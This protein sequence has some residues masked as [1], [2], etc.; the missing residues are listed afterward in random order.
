MIVYGGNYGKVRI[1]RKGAEFGFY[2]KINCKGDQTG[3]VNVTSTGCNITAS[4]NCAGSSM[5]SN[6]N[7][8]VAK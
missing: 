4:E 2:A 8:S 6:R 1:A 7:F 3:G 5:D